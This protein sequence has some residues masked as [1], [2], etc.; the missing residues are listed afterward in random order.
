MPTRKETA[1]SLC[2]VAHDTGYAV[3]LDDFLFLCAF[4]NLLPK[5]RALGSVP[6]H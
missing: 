2:I 1:I 3:V 4:K 5:R 6:D